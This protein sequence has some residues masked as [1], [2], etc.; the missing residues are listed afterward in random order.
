[1]GAVI[2]VIAAVVP[3]WPLAKIHVDCVPFDQWQSGYQGQVVVIR[4]SHWDRNVHP[5]DAKK[6]VGIRWPRNCSE[7]KI[8]SAVDGGSE[9]AR[10][11]VHCVANVQSCHLVK[12]HQSGW[13][14]R[15]PL[16]EEGHTG[17]CLDVVV[18]NNCLVSDNPETK[19]KCVI[20]ARR[21]RTNGIIST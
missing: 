16:N 11:Y 5:I 2:A 9:H 18:A 1:V 20:A 10:R 8:I 13:I 12:N 4:R 15:D 21:T 7:T 3:I 14:R 19:R 17:R 6:N